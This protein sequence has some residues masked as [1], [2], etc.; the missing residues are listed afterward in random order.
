MPTRPLRF[1]RAPKGA[2]CAYAAGCNR[3]A[4]PGLYLC[5]RHKRLMKRIGEEHAQYAERRG[6]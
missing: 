1:K 5:S 3:P 6:A 4:V 2:R